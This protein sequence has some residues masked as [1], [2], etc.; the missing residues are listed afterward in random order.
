MG[1]PDDSDCGILTKAPKRASLV[2]IMMKG[3]LTLKHTQQRI[4]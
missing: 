1:R 3:S 4:H 2:D